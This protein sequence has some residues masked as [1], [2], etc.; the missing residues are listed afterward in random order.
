MRLKP[1][2]YQREAIDRT[3]EAY[4]MGFEKA[5]VVLPTGAGKALRVDQRVMTPDGWRAIGDI[6][7]GDFVIGK[8]GRP[9]LVQGVFPQGQ[10]EMFRVEVTDGA[11]VIC[12]AEHLWTVRTKHDKN[13]CYPWRTWTLREMMRL[14]INSNG[15]NRWELPMV[16]P[17]EFTER[18]LPLDPYLL[19]VILGD[20]CLAVPGQVTLTLEPELAATLTL[21]PGLKLHAGAPAGAARNYQITGRPGR[22][23]NA[24][25]SAIRALGLEGGRSTAKFIPNIYM[26][27]PV[28]DRLALL[29]GLMDTDGYVERTAVDFTV[30]CEQ[31]ALDAQELV[32]SLGGK[33][34]ISKRSTAWTY[35]GEKKHGVAWRLRIVLEGMCPVRWKAPRCLERTKYTAARRIKSVTPCG[36]G[37]AVCIKVEA[38]DGLF[39]TEGYVVTHNTIF[40]AHLIKEILEEHGAGGKAL[41]IAHRNELLTQARDKYKAVDP[42]ELVGIFQGNKRETWARVICASI[43]SCYGDKKSDDGLHVLR[44]GRRKLL[45]LKDLKLVVIDECHHAPAESYMDLIREIREVAPDCVFVGVTAT[46][47]RGDSKGLGELW[48]CTLEEARNGHPRAKNATGALVYKMGIDECMELGFLVPLAPHSRR[49]VIDADISGVKISKTT[50]DFETKSLSKVINTP[51]IRAEIVNWWSKLAGPGTPNAPPFGRPTVA[52]CCGIEGAKELAKAFCMD[53]IRAA[54]VWG[55]G[56]ALGWTEDEGDE[57]QE[58]SREE[59]IRAFQSGEV[60][61]LCNCQVLTE[62]WDESLVSCVLIGRPVSEE[63]VGA[64]VQMAGRGLRLAGASLAESIRN[65]K[66]D[67]LLIDFAGASAHGVCSQADLRK[68]MFVEGVE[69]RPKPKAKEDNAEALV[70]AGMDHVVQRAVIHGVTEYAVDLFGSRVAWPIIGGVR[71]CYATHG[72]AVLVYPQPDGTHSAIAMRDKQFRVLADK[73]G[74]KEAL[75]KAS[76]FALLHGDPSYLRPGPWFTQKPATDQQMGRLR[77]SIEANQLIDAR[78]AALDS[79]HRMLDLASLP[80]KPS[81]AQAFAWIAY[82]QCRI[83]FGTKIAERVDDLFTADERADRLTRLRLK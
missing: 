47:S 33:A 37:Q 73:L 68:P 77:A 66:E 5:L 60:T 74:E 28:K 83:A 53:G 42:E 61:V 13:D 59:A 50:R 6:S 19:G 36:V 16:E 56:G 32:R 80:E 41:I 64:F 8:N 10:R 2:P 26:T 1:R 40:F 4:D 14:G 79:S 78:R 12:D 76:A 30:A 24:V 3:R 72:L 7:P 67:C 58:V 51:E 9:T 25:L 81:M 75:G 11:V 15:G 55:D 54:A 43:A 34:T 48:Q 82:L 44:Q 22:S 20:G 35:K 21:P 27:A 57:G 39:V 52:F 38:E 18:D 46:P 69:E 49:V 31:L 29:Q 63:A 17:V 70:F 71:V 23:D 45:P 62:G 65:G